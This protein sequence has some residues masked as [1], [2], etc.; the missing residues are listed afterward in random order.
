MGIPKEI[1][2]RVFDLFFTTKEIGQGTGQGLALV[3]AIVVERHGGT[4]RLETELG[5]GTA[6]IIRLPVGD[7]PEPCAAACSPDAAAAE[8]NEL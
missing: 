6:F 3:H 2:S 1:R 8:T 4:I 7:S 5:V